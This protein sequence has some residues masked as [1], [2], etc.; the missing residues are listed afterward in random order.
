M[1]DVGGRTGLATNWRERV[2]AGFSV[3]ESEINA[4]LG[5]EGVVV[6][7]LEDLAFPDDGDLVGVANRRQSMRDRDRR[8]THLRDRDNRGGARSMV[9]EVAK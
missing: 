9:N 5:H 7:Q 4:L 8:P 2:S 6:A 3:D 1:G